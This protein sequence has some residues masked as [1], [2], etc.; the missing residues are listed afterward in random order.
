MTGPR[1]RPG[2]LDISPYVGGESGVPGAKDVIRLASNE[3]ALGASPKARAAYESVA[4][5]LHR[6]PDGASLALRQAIG[7]IHGFDPARIVCGAGSDEILSL[8]GQIYAGPGDEIVYSEYGF[9]MFKI[10]ALAVGA[11]PVAAPET[12]Y[13]ADIDAILAAVNEHTRIVI[14]ANPNNPTGTYLNA[15][16]MQRLRAGLRGDIVLVIDAAY[17]EYVDAGDYAPGVELVDAGENVVM[18]RTFSKIYGLA[19]LRLGWCYAPSSIADLLNRVR[20]PFN[21]TA[22]AQAAGEAAVNDADFI[23]DSQRHNSQWR[24]WLSDGLAGLG[25]TVTPSIANFVL[26]HFKDAGQSAAAAEFLKGRNILL[27]G[28]GGYGLPQCLRIGVGLEEENRLVIE[29]LGEFLKA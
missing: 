10:L 16:E 13:R 21:V 2:V 18:T 11:K 5:E 7:R 26:V 28:M 8:L 22:A 1:P 19:A 24:G 17:A 15:G 9:L 6:Y 29:T 20:G 25:L 12:G 4:A 3:S 14:L 23:E 27:R